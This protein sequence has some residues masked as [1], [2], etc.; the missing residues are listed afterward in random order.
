MNIRN[1]MF[2]E[3]ID[4]RRGGQKVNTGQDHVDGETEWDM[5]DCGLC[6]LFA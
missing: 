6:T 1:Q 3:P 2:F 4:H 5:T